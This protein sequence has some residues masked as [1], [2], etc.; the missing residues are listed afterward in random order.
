MAKEITLPQL[1]Q[2]MEEGTLVNCL[3]KVGDQ[4]KRGEVIFEIETDRAM[5]EME[6][7]VEGFVKHIVA[8]VAQTLPI[9]APMIVLG[10]KDEVV[11]QS[12][13]DALTPNQSQR[14]REEKAHRRQ[15]AAP[16]FS[17]R[18]KVC[19]AVYL[20]GCV[21]LYFG[22]PE[23]FIDFY[24]THE[25]TYE[26]ETDILASLF[27]A[28]VELIR[29]FL[30]VVMCGWAVAIPVGIVLGFLSWGHDLLQYLRR[31]TIRS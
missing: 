1:G 6:S 22:V 7:P 26:P 28:A 19:C 18:I 24:A 10:E 25:W 23:S 31:L 8:K 5:F 9:G 14:I 2:M 12:F 29:P 4:V 16:A 11:P 17:K 20:L 13:L 30:A 15:H 3:V 21:L 27:N